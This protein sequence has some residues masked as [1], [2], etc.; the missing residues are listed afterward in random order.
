[1][2]VKVLVVAEVVIVVLVGWWR[3]RMKQAERCVPSEYLG[4]TGE[5]GGAGVWGLAG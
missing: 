3:G 5:K 4:P 2:V 1:M